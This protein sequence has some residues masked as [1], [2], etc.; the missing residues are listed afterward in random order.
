[1]PAYAVSAF[2]L[3]NLLTSPISAISF[4]ART[5]PTP[6]IARTVEYS[7]TESVTIHWT[8]FLRAYTMNLYEERKFNYVREK[9]T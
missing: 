4:G 5:S 3:W 1:M 7:G 2:A 9:A 6:P 8:D